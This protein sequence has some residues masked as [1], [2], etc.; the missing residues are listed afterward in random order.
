L[1]KTGS[2]KKIG[3]TL[4]PLPPRSPYLSP[5]GF[6]LFGTLKDAISGKAF[7]RKDEVNKEARK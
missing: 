1:K 5:S 6:R 2:N 4:L 3:W 7:G